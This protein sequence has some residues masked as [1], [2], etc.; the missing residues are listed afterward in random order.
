MSEEELLKAMQIRMSKDDVLGRY[1]EHESLKKLYGLNQRE[2]FETETI[3]FILGY[4]KPYC[5]APIDIIPFGRTGGDG[6]YFAFLTDFGAYDSIED[7]PIVFIS[8]T[9]FDDQKPGQA[10][11]MFAENFMDFLSI[12]TEMTYAEIIRFEDLKTMD[13]ESKINEIKKETEIY[14]SPRLKQ[15]QQSTIKLLKENFRIT[16]IDDLNT[17]YQDLEK[18]RNGENSVLLIDGINLTTKARNHSVPIKLEAK[19]SSTDLALWLHNAKEIS[20]LA[21]YREAQYI[22][23][24][25]DDS[26]NEILKVIKEQ[27]KKDNLMRESRILEFEINQNNLSKKYY[28]IRKKN[29]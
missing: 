19:L 3:G 24:F 7:C 8:P 11:K 27:M 29:K 28:E 16:K 26:Y 6:C 18:E 14:D 20:K 25:S 4:D 22:Y 12:M 10:N 15:L 5:P 17:Y 9:D 1:K 23:S 2:D 13:F 21:F